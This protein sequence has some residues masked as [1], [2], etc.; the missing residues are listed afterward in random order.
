MCQRR[1]PNCV[2][3]VQRCDS[4]LH[5]PLGNW[6]I[7]RHTNSRSVKSRTGSLADWI[8]RGPDNLR[9]GKLADWCKN[10]Y[11]CDVYK[12][13]LAEFISPWVIQSTSSIDQSVTWLTVSWF[14]GELS[15][16]L[17]VT[18]PVSVFVGFALDLYS[19]ASWNNSSALCMLYNWKKILPH[20]ITVSVLLEKY[21]L[22]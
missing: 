13:A 9:T 14:I 15:N 7:R 11:K 19:A 10:R 1:H 6:T 21:Q 22:I 2:V 18:V 5:L 20:K 3:K 4:L 17:S 8:T 16:K 12:F